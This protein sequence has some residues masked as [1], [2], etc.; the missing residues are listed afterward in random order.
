M[1]SDE[2][3][4]S[5][6]LRDVLDHGHRRESEVGAR[7]HTDDARHPTRLLGRDAE[8]ARVRDEGSD[9][10]GVERSFGG[11]VVQEPRGAREERGI[12]DPQ[13]RVPQIDPGPKSTRASPSS[14]P[15]SR[16]TAA[17]TLR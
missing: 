16:L 17:C 4:T 14:S 5:E 10:D 3:R 13:D 12:L 2:D 8:E 6:R 11:E 1:P 15:S 9:E 7:E